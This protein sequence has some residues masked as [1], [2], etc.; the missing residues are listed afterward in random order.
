[1]GL[2]GAGFA[3]S[4][5]VVA[6]VAVAACVRFLP[7]YSGVG[8]GQVAARTALLVGGQ[9]V[10]LLALLVLINSSMQFYSSWRDLFGMDVGPVRV[11]ERYA[12]PPP[13]A[14][15]ADPARDALTRLLPAR[16][17]RL[18]L[19]DL[20]GPRSGV[21]AKV[22]VYV[23]PRYAP[24]RRRPAPALLFLAPPREAIVGRR[25][26]WLAARE[27]AAGRLRPM[28]IVVAPV[29]AGCVD[30]P[31]RTQGETFFSEDL[32]VLVDAAYHLGG[33][34]GAWSVAGAQGT[35]S[36]CA[37]LLAMRHSDRFSSAVFTAAALTPPAG[38]LYG[39]SQSIRDEY[40]PRW[41]LRHRPPPPV[42]VGVVGDNGFSAGARPPMRAEP[43]PATAW[44]S[45][46][47]VLRWLGAHLPPGGRA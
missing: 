2:T 1:M 6:L 30:A 40:D 9:A 4:L 36:Y 26:P 44:A 41:R 12:G 8:R 22:Y 29:G 34:P 10:L 19:L 33:A 17:G 37:A 7:R 32:P 42:S 14:S 28:P 31:G 35:A 13:V 27:I 5:M 21:S 18:D 3:G 23:P 46:P 15:S 24:D 47:T 20:H 25:L 38:D 11:S 45:L 43:L 16:D 39:G